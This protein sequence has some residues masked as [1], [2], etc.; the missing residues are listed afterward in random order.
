MRNLLTV[1]DSNYGKEFNTTERILYKNIYSS[2]S[3]VAMVIY[4]PVIINNKEEVQI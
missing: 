4:L 2:Q 1:G 3:L